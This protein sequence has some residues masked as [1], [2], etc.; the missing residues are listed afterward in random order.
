L[1]G[2]IWTLGVFTLSSVSTEAYGSL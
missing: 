1:S 2:S